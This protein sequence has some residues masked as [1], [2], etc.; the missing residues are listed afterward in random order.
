MIELQYFQ[1]IKHLILLG[2]FLI[3]AVGV[4]CASVIYKESP[5]GVGLVCFFKVKPDH[6]NAI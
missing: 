1:K 3:D 6:N 4:I 2:G 5:V